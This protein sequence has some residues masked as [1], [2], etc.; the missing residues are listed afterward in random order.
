M[1]EVLYVQAI[2]RLVHAR[3]IIAGSRP[4][5]LFYKPEQFDCVESGSVGREFPA[6]SFDL[7]HS[8][9]ALLRPPCDGIPAP[10]L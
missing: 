1:Q 5:I 8:V 6:K 2:A 3:C 9:V 7:C 4:R 10:W